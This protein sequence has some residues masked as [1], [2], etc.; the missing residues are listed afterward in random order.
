MA[1]HH[2]YGV[3]R[4]GADWLVQVQRLGHA[5]PSQHLVQHVPANQRHELDR[6]LEGPILASLSGQRHVEVHLRKPGEMKALTRPEAGF[7]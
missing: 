1:Q 7:Q 3:H 6:D 4:V 5:P 2:V